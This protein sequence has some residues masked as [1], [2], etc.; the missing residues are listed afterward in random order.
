MTSLTSSGQPNTE[1]GKSAEENQ[2]SRTSSSEH[3]STTTVTF[4]K[5]HPQQPVKTIQTISYLMKR[6]LLRSSNR[7]IT[8]AFGK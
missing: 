4:N 8:A 2:V 5:C 6:H 7:M 1:N 3:Q